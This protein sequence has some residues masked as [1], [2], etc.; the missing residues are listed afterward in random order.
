MP[1]PLTKITNL[2]S[3]LTVSNRGATR[4][5]STAPLLL[6]FYELVPTFICICLILSQK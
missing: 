3:A 4:L 6:H 2:P 5:E 1:L